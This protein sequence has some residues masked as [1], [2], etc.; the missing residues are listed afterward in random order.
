MS[1]E[2]ATHKT[3]KY[4]LEPTPEQAQTLENILWQCHTLY[5][6]ALEQRKTWWQRG[7]NVGAT[8]PQ[9]KAELPDLKERRHWRISCGNAIHSIISLWNSAK[10]GGNAA[11]M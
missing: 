8:Y 6:I 4:R 9:Q 11:K 5:N 3:Y 1:K 10:P 2:T 7:Q